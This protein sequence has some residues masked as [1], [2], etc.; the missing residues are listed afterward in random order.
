MMNPEQSHAVLSF[1][2]ATE[3]TFVCARLLPDI[4]YIAVF[5]NRV[6][7]FL[8]PTVSTIQFDAT[9]SSWYVVFFLLFAFIICDQK[10]SKPML[11]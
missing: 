7:Y 9:S 6:V 5:S 1:K 3:Q 8:T 11:Q 2:P 4:W 10:W